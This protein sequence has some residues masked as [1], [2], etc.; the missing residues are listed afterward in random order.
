MDDKTIHAK[1]VASGKRFRF[2]SNWRKFLA[3]L[4]D[5]R[6]KFAEDSLK[7][8]LEAGSL[9]GK[10]F[11]DVGSGSGLFSLAAR[12]LGARVHSFDFDTQSFECTKELKRRFFNDDPDWVVAQASALDEN[13]IRSLGKFDIVYSWGVLHHTGRMWDALDK[14]AE[15]AGEGGKLFVSIYNDQGMAS[16]FWTA[17]KKTYNKS[18]K[19]IKFLMV[20][21]VWGFWESRAALARCLRFENPL[22]FS[23]WKE[24][25]NQRG[26]SIWHDMVDWVGGYPFEVAK[27]EQIFDFYRSRGFN[28]TKLKTCA[29]SHGCN[30]FV[31]IKSPVS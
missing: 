24:L 4:N 17:V 19:F 18:P 9:A 5:E 30:E 28:L 7:K 31:F 1:E 25:S 26:M 22:P 27:P 13:Y 12:R 6:I 3:T 2:G 15:L 8:M 10:S 16:R 21:S 29:G 23:A 11:V 14:V 20:A